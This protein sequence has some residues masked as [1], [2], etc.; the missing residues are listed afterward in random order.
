MAKCADCGIERPY[1]HTHHIVPRSKGGTDD[2]SNLVKL[3]ANCHE[4]RHGGSFHL[5]VSNQSRR[6]HSDRLKRLWADAE[7]R[8]RMSQS[9]RNRK[10]RSAEALAKQSIKEKALWLDPEYRAKQSASRKMAWASL[11]AEA[12]A[13]RL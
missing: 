13:A 3:C 10:P 4:N 2:P 12:R 5:A 7:F 8:A 9:F 11:S 1:L 6:S